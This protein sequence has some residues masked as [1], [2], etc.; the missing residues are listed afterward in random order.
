MLRR[1]Q[2]QWLNPIA[3]WLL[4]AFV[5]W[6]CWQIAAVIWLI[7]APPQPP[8]TRDVALRSKPNTVP[9]LSAVQLFKMERPDL[10]AVAPSVMGFNQPMRLQG[11]MISRPASGSSAL[12]LMGGTAERYR[13]GDTLKD[14]QLEVTS[15][16]WDSV[17][18]R[19]PD[20]SV[21]TLNF[22]E[23]SPMSPPAAAPLQSPSTTSTTTP[24]ERVDS[25]LADAQAQLSSN[26]ASYLTRMGLSATGKG[27][28]ITAGVPA[29]IRNQ[30][31]LRPGDRIV[32]VNG[33]TLGQPQNDAKLLEQVRQT[34]NAQIEIQRGEQTLTIQQSF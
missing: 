14:L 31:G 3:P 24:S 22:G 26:P 7:A 2:W 30:M 13:I 4:A 19:R 8:L 33:Q 29:G 5:L 21:V 1:I 16:S 28:E 12:I 23:E 20:G 17:Q 9:N 27:Y 18:L 34:R 15:V 32:S 11:V 6:L 25:A 10:T